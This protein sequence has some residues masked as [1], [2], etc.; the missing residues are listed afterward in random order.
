M[1]FG[2]DILSKLDHVKISFLQSEIF[3]GMSIL[4]FFSW[5]SS[6]DEN[7]IRPRDLL[8]NVSSYKKNPATVALTTF[9]RPRTDEM[10]KCF[11]KSPILWEITRLLC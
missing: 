4:R 2:F 5:I 10:L 6:F 7:N 3:N 9:A 8:V 11:V 1:E